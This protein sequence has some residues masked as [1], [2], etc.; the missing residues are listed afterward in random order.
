[1]VSMLV[2][3]LGLEEDLDLPLQPVYR[4]GTHVRTGAVAHHRQLWGAQ[5][6]SRLIE[7]VDVESAP[8]RW[9]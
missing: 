9:A 4:P 6:L 2:T 8:D 3:K 1:M 5:R 7:N